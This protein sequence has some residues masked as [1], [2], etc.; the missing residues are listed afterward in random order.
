MEVELSVGEMEKILPCPC[1]TIKNNLRSFQLSIEW[2]S[3]KADARHKQRE[4]DRNICLLAQ[5]LSAQQKIFLL[6]GVTTACINT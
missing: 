2:L 4:L 3:R 5:A 1:F 6:R